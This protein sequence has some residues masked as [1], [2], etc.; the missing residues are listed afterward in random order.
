MTD[1]P[2]FTISHWAASL[3]ARD[4]GVAQDFV[5]GYRMAGLPE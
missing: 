5:D 3:P 2:K 4:H 1:S